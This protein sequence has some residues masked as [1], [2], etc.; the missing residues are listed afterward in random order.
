MASDDN[1]RSFMIFGHSFERLLWR[2][3]EMVKQ[4]IHSILCSDIRLQFAV[5]VSAD[6][7][8]LFMVTDFLI[9]CLDIV[10]LDPIFNIMF[11]HLLHKNW[12]AA[13]TY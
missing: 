13:I 4:A 9:E 2:K 5:T 8:A 12:K 6:L 1:M 11:L 7:A 3:E 10:S